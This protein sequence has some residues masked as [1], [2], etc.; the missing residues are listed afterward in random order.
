MANNSMTILE[1]FHRLGATKDVDF[2]REGVKALAQAVMELEVKVKT[3]A[4][5]HARTADRKVYRNGYRD[6]IWDTRVGR[7]D[8]KIPKVREGSFFPSLLEPQRRAEKA[9]LTVVQEA[10]VHG[11]STR[12]VDDLV[13]SLGLEGVSKSEVSRICSELDDLVEQFRNRPLDTAYPY[14]WLDATYI[15]VR[16]NGHVL[17]MAAVVAVGVRSTGEREV[18]GLDLGPA[19]DRT[20]WLSFLRSLVARGLHGVRLVISD[21]HEGLKGA[22]SAALAM[23]TWQRCRVH[24][25]RNVL[26]QI[27]KA[28]QSVVGAAVRSIFVQPDQEAA[29]EQLRRVA[30]G[31]QDKYPK[32]AAL[33][34]DAAE[35]VLAY[36]AFPSEH[37]RQIHSTNTL[38]RLNFE[39]KRRT[40][41]V[42]I[43]PNR[44]AVIRLVG[45]VL[46]EQNDEWLTG[47][48]YFSQ[49]SMSKLS[50]LSTPPD[51]SGLLAAD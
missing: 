10:Y 4:D 9:L 33:L 14:L 47:R 36:M 28:A 19:E 21:A 44:A 3:G 22:L 27:P 15:K 43:F 51:V 17:G 48:R 12:K 6:R 25:M 32:V 37:R 45:A 7:I 40:D 38:E 41:V 24:F 2:L 23:A 39:I 46:A 5:K 31:L 18:L 49:E 11:V 30:D 1:L 16:E 29:R 26:S 13:K 50:E 34:D 35:D 20:F 42:G 8:L